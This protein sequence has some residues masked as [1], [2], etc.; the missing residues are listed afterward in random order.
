[1]KLEKY[2]KQ[3]VEE[4]KASLRE[5]NKGFGAVIAKNGQVVSSAHDTECTEN[6]A[7]AHAELLAIQKASRKVG[8]N[9][10]DCILV[11]THEPCPMC[12]TAV[13]WSG[14]AEIAYGFSTKEAI[15][16]GRRRIDLSCVEL[17]HRAGVKVV[18]HE[19]VLHEEC[20]VLYR[21]DVRAE[22]RKLRNAN[23]EALKALN[24]NSAQ[25][26]VKWFKENREK[27]EDVITK[28]ILDSGYRL[29]LERLGITEDQAPVVSRTE[30][31][32]VFHSQNFCPTLE[33]CKILGVDTRIICRKLNENATDTL[34]KQIDPHLEFSRNYQ[35]L[36][37]YTKY[38]EESIR[39]AEK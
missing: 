15:K 21:E 11:S 34:L 13:I 20:T 16:Q 35:N 1:M 7:T 12:A 14:I 33:A 3:A 24:I 30:H 17:F 5:G 29:L 6:D 28:D 22:I 9:L 18:V 32:I 2:M 10:S 23:D 37:P 38:C 26:R 39:I 19:K 31:E 8:K 36:R 4:A 27:L 25:R